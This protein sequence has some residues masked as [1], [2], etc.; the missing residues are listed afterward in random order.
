MTLAK[1]NA[2]E[3]WGAT[4]FEKPLA[5]TSVGNQFRMRYSATSVGRMMNHS[6][7]EG[8]ARPSANR[9]SRKGMRGALVALRGA[10]GRV[11]GKK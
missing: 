3:A 7:T 9:T 5:S 2:M 10:A 11:S 4:A 6:S 1:L 8:M